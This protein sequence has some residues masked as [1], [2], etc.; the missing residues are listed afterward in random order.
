VNAL[1]F[2]VAQFDFA[3]PLDRPRKDWV[4]SFSIVPGF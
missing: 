2:A 3:R 4:F 1:G